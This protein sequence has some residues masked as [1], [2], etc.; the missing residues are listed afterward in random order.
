M[1]NNGINIDATKMDSLV[2]QDNSYNFQVITSTN[3]ENIVHQKISMK[4]EMNQ[5]KR[6]L[7]GDCP[8][9][10]EQRWLPF[11]EWLVG[12]AGMARAPIK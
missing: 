6:L 8:A 1:R 11:L 2:F 7:R 9:V 12:A 4:N 5:N 3:E 10:L